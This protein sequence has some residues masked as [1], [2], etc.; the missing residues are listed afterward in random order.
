M[1]QTTPHRQAVILPLLSGLAMSLGWGI[2]GD[3][4]H[5]A[6]AMLPGALVA[7]AIVLTAG[8]EDWLARAGTLAML[9]AVGWAFG[10]QMSYGIVIGYTA[11]STLADVV[12]GYGSL[13][14]IGALWGGIG[15]GVLALGLTWKRERLEAFVL[16]LVILYALWSI[17]NLT[18]IVA[19]L[20]A[21]WSFHDTDWV[22]AA[23]ALLVGGLFYLRP[24]PKREA[25]RLM[26][27][28]G[29][30]WWVGFGLLTLLLGLRMT[31]PRSDNWAGCVG[32]F[33]ALAI[34]LWREGNRAA[35]LLVLYGLL[36]GGLGFA[37]GDFVQMLGRAGWGPIG[38]HE[39]LQQLDYWK[40]MERLFGLIM[41]C[42]L[43][44][45]VCRLLRG[46]LA[47][48]ETQPPARSLRGFALAV[49]LIVMPW[50]NF[51]TNVRVWM[52]RE[53]FRDSLLG[54]A[55]LGWILTIAILLTILLGVAI[56]RH[57][58]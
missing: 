28:L 9:G 12:Y 54:V 27:A 16:P 38:Q 43:G 55:P 46:E 19:R 14:L 33:L 40:W 42:G 45:G 25:A 35:L 24:G 18:T 3:Y 13:F 4:G 51:V 17:L 7:L 39:A 44:F 29:G 8:R 1:N 6:G 34:Y 21:R 56:H 50:E 20:E 48:V 53:Q 41:G 5:E 22:A 15:A 37:V 30:G 2:R 52:E 26:L 11:A 10:G 36:A 58:N 49:L 23:A 32:L 31:P 47:P 57:L